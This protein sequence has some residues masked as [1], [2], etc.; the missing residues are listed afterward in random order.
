MK[1]CVQLWQTTTMRHPKKMR[2]SRFEPGFIISLL[3]KH[4]A[5]GPNCS[6]LHILYSPTPSHPILS[7]PPHTFKYHNWNPK[8]TLKTWYS[9]EGSLAS[10]QIVFV[11]NASH[12]SAFAYT[13]AITCE[14]TQRPP[15][16]TG[17]KLP[18]A[19]SQL[20]HQALRVNMRFGNVLY[21]YYHRYNSLLSPPIQ[22]SLWMSYLNSIPLKW[23]RWYQSKAKLFNSTTK[24]LT[25][26]WWHMPSV[27]Y[28][29][30]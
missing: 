3:A 22:V 10:Q 29:E 6:S 4:P 12:C 8:K 21:Y 5:T 30:N 15:L 27:M 2:Q 7:I 1:K 20:I 17:H 16:K 28:V 14:K 11:D 25:H 18:S 13:C 19:S 9:P 24:S 26:G 23:Q